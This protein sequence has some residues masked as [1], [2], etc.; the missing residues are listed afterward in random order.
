V[1]GISH[2]YLFI[3]LMYLLHIRAG[4]GEDGPTHQPIETISGLRLIPGLDVIRPGDPEETAGAFVAALERI[5]GPTLLALTRQNIPYLEAI[6]V[7][8]R[9]DGTLRGGTCFPAF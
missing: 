8:V 7:N 4:V 5:D 1:F 3:V 2:P 6:D 9:R